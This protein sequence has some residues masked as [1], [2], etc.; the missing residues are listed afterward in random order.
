MRIE[1]GKM[2]R[3]I[4]PFKGISLKG[5]GLSLTQSLLKYLVYKMNRA[6]F[7]SPGEGLCGSC[8]KQR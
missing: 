8:V 1:K 7:L 3:V 2:E 6:L 4:K 5:H